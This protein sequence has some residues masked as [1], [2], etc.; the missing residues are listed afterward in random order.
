MKEIE[1]ELKFWKRIGWIAIILG[2]ILEGIV[3]F[4]IPREDI[5]MTNSFEIV[6]L[7]ANETLMNEL[8]YNIN[9][10]CQWIAESELNDLVVYETKASDL[11]KGI[12]PE[13]FKEAR[14]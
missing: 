4:K 13:L 9:I 11:C 1:R 3:F 8:K 14:Q 7:T 10:D 2:L 5:D 12:F 6:N